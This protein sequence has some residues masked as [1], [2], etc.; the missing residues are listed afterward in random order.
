MFA[1]PDR[2]MADGGGLWEVSGKRDSVR[3]PV[4]AHACSR[5]SCMGASSGQEG[6]EG[7]P[8]APVARFGAN[9]GREIIFNGGSQ[10]GVSNQ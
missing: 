2:A 7:E 5:A 4:M 6:R 8:S 10:Y 9:S 3:A 1:R